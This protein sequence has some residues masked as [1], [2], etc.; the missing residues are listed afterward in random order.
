MNGSQQN[1]IIGNSIAATSALESMRR[2]GFQ[3]EIH[4]VSRESLPAYT[5]TVLQYLIDGRVEESRLALKEERDYQDQ[6]VCLF[7]GK[8]VIRVKPKDRKI[9]TSDGGEMEFDQLLIATG[10]IPILPPI[11]GIRSERVLTL[12]T[13]EDAR[14]I[15][16]FCVKGNQVLIIGAGLIGLPLAETFHGHGMGVTVVE[17]ADQ[18]LPQSLDSVSAKILRQIFEQR[19]IIIKTGCRVMEVAERSGKLTAQLSNGTEASSD[20]MV[21]AAGVRPNIDLVRESGIHCGQGILVDDRMRTNYPMIYAAGD[22]AEARHF[23]TGEPRLNPILPDAMEQ[24]RVAGINMAGGSAEYAGGLN[25]N[26]ATFFKNVFFSA[27]LI[28]PT[29]DGY[30]LFAFHLPEERVYRKLVFKDEVLVGAIL[31]NG[32]IDPGAIQSLI[33]ERCDLRVWKRGLCSPHVLRENWLGWILEER[34]LAG[35]RYVHGS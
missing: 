34:G 7:L 15:R 10:T 16:A 11:E 35:G 26:I 21:V 14:Q 3:G 30:E 18:P 20:F 17:M 27:G 29:G 4:L 23:L 6:G 5:P 22:V 28:D 12:R 1:M 33:L 2:A 31:I 9:L 13:L 32:P 25:M 8:E 19:G 24:G